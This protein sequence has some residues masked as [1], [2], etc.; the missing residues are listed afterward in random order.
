MA[1]RNKKE[2]PTA[3]RKGIYLSALIY[4]EGAQP[5]AAD[6]AALA[7]SALTN[8]LSQALQTGHDGL[9]MKL[10]KLEVQNDVEEDNEGQESGE[11]GGK[12]EF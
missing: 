12:F 10:R 8:T 4:V 5:P 9:S 11:K 6:F 3:I 7:K 2:S 1:T